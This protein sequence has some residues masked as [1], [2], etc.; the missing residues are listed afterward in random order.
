MFSKEIWEGPTN[1]KLD[2]GKK[3]KGVY[4]FRSFLTQAKMNKL[5]KKIFR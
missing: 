2:W 3:A 1:H 5:K 4:L